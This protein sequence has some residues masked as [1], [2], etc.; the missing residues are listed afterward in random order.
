M[1]ALGEACQRNQKLFVIKV[2]D[3]VIVGVDSPVE[4]V[5]FKGRKKMGYQDDEKPEESFSSSVVVKG[6]LK[7]N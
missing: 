6:C 4:S 3:R 5:Y 2:S 1:Q 7:E